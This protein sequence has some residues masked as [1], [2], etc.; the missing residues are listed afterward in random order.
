MAKQS[1][2]ETDPRELH[3][4]PPFEE[5]R[6][7]PPGEEKEMRTRPDHGEETYRG[8]DR[9]RGKAAL[10]TGGD[11]GI[12]KAIAIAYAREGADVAISCLP[13]EE[14]DAQDTVRWVKDARRKCLHMPGNIGD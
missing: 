2:I 3:K 9:M 12:G 10:I 13:Q 8:F 14:N 4:K 6:Q 11:S 1:T 7:A 5:P